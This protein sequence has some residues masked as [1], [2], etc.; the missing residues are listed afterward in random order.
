MTDRL[1]ILLVEDDAATRRALSAHLSRAGDLVD[2][3]EDGRA[4]LALLASRDYQLVLADVRSPHVEIQALSEAACARTACAAVVP[5]SAFASVEHVTAAIR[6]GVYDYLL[7]PVEAQHVAALLCRVRDRISM[8]RRL[9]ALRGTLPVRDALE[10]L[11][12][13]GPSMASLN[14]LVREAAGCDTPVLLTGE[15]GTGR[16]LVA[17]AIHALSKRAELPLVRIDCKDSPDRLARTLFDPSPDHGLVASARGGTLVLLSVE[18][19]TRD[20]RAKV[21]QAAQRPDSPRVIAVSAGI[22]SVPARRGELFA[23]VRGIEIV[24]P[25]LR[26]RREDIPRLAE[27]YASLASGGH[28][29]RIAPDVTAALIDAP[30]EGNLPALEA[31]MRGAIARAAGGDVITREHLPPELAARVDNGSALVEQVEAYERAVVRRALEIVHGAVARA[32]RELGV[33][34]RTL[35]RKMRQFGIA[36]ESFRKRSRPKQ[37]PVCAPHA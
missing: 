22:P 19:L 26:E 9:D 25:P 15:E 37:L 35:R 6:Q 14:K 17:S 7:K 34:E 20:L 4:A 30:W 18:A 11:M 31:V 29:P 13:G 33:P 12:A 1:R 21:L 32:A 10:V 16:R 28:A 5:M 24:T 27:H 23:W 2:A 36:K 8:R 3:A